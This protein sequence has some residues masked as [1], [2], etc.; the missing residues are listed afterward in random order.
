M[1]EKPLLVSTTCLVDGRGRTPLTDAG[2]LV[3]AE[4]VIS[5]VGP[6]AQ[7]PQLPD[8]CRHVALPGTLLPG[9]IDAHVHF[10]VPGGGLNVG[11]LMRVP[12]PVRVLQIAASMR[13]TLD[14]GVTTVRDLGFLGPNLAMMA[15]TGATPAPR[16]LNAIT[17]LSSTGGH[18]DFP[19]PAGVDLTK[20]FDLLDLPMS[21]A[22]GPDEVTK[23]ARQLIRDGA[24]VIKV[25]A[26]GGVS[27][28][29]EGPDDVGLS[30]AELRAVVE[31]A[32]SRGRK[33]AA[34]AIGT[35]GI[36][37]AVDAGVALDALVRACRSKASDWSEIAEAH[38]QF[39][40]ALVAGAASPRIGDAYMRLATELNL[41]LAQLRPVWSRRRMIDHHR[42]LVHDLETTGDVMALR[43][44]LQDGL[45]AV[46]DNS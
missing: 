11:M 9:F 37:N 44:H 36:S 20:L 24:Q 19:L 25:A 18:A 43:R 33:V 2:V 23:H 14:A 30:P 10:A 26:T 29:A 5:W 1:P 41:F 27:T 46:L 22:D 21:V 8:D 28:P 31:T 34:H 35:E 45:E 7:A 15:T 12:P 13:A 32:A 6:M 42:A 38:A 17:M 16:L 39:H 4:G 3:D 40:E